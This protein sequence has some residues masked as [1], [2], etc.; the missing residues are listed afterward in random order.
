MVEAAH[1]E[2]RQ[3]RQECDEFVDGKL[4]DFEETLSGVLRT[5]S[6]DRAALR[7]GAGASGG[8]QRG[9]RAAGAAGAAGTRGTSRGGYDYDER[10][11]SQPRRE[12]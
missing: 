6:S 9:D 2:S 12:G 7:R 8:A 5:V 11:W 10:G 4:A 1:S 3:L